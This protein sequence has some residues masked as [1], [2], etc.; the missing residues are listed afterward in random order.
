M[1]DSLNNIASTVILPLWLMLIVLLQKMSPSIISMFIRLTNGATEKERKLGN[2]IL[3]CK[4]EL[5]QMSMTADYVKYVKCERQIIKLEQSLK[6]LVEC[7]KQSGS[8]ASSSLNMGMYILMGILF[9]ATMYSTYASPVVKNLNEEWFFPLNYLFGFPTG[10]STVIGVPF[11]ML[12]FR[13]F[14]NALGE[15]S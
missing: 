14:V 4:K 11:F 2:E 8:Y 6:P 13:T 7:R 15:Y 3:N 12:M 10:L 5:S 9:A 1:L